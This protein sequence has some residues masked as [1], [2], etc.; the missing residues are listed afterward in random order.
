MS[1]TPLAFRQVLVAVD[2]SPHSDLA[3][4]QAIA[5]AQRDRAR[6]TILTVVPNVG[7]SAAMSYGA[8]V[9]PVA[10][11]VDADRAGAT[12]LR[13]AL[14]AVPDDLPVTT[15]QRHG[16]AGPEIVAQ[17]REGR[18]D[19]VVLGARGLGRIGALVGSVSQ[20]VLHH[21]GV[22]VFVAHAPCD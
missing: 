18:H 12:A 6:L 3:L 15:V 14:E 13:E 7:E 8:G 20:Y 21:A 11:Q 17:A 4:Q 10:M 19:A 1:D 22:A 2:G 9:D 5:L 16:H